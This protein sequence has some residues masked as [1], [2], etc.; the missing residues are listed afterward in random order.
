MLF[1]DENFKYLSDGLN[2]YSKTSGV[3][4]QDTVP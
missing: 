4:G 2:G 1:Y 3:E